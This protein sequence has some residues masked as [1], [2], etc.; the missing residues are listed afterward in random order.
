M[1]MVTILCLLYLAVG[2]LH[3]ANALGVA[4]RGFRREFMEN[5][6]LRKKVC[7][8]PVW[9]ALDFGAFTLAACAFHVFLWPILRLRPRALNALFAPLIGRGR[10]PR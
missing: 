5:V 9:T 2:C 3:G 4:V 1:S 8:H 7:E 10:R 6:R